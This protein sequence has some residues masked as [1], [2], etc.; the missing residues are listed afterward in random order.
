VARHPGGGTID[1]PG[2]PATPVVSLAEL[3]GLPAGA[4]AGRQVVVL[5]AGARRLGIA[6][7]RVVRRADVLVRE[8]HP[9]IAAIPGL[10]GASR[11][12]DG[13]IVLLLDPEGLF[14]LALSA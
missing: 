3:L 4:V 8:S 9:A 12:G 6:V 1:L 14:G 7:E 13:S 10:G 2:F 5:G 11:L